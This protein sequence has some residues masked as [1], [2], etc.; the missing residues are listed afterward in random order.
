MGLAF[1]WTTTL[2]FWAPA[3]YPLSSGCSSGK[4]WS[5]TEENAL[6]AHALILVC[7]APLSLPPA[8]ARKQVKC[9]GLTGS[10]AIPLLVA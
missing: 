7:V 1:G 9:M 6:A 8:S 10:W 5:L 4:A 2:A 3:R